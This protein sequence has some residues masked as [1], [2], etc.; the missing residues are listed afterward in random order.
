MHAKILSFASPVAFI[1]FDQLVRPR[2]HFRR[3]RHADLF[4]WLYVDHEL[5]LRRLLHRQIGGFR[6]LQNSIHVICDAPVT[7]RRVH[8][9]RNERLV[10]G[11][12]LT[13]TPIQSQEI[14]RGW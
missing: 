1:S 10:S 11:S 13:V 8:P 14:A 2:Q 5:E 4:R 6:S 7:V 12:G 3:N 9:V